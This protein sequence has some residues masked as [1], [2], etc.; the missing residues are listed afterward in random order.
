MQSNKLQEVLSWV[1]W[2]RTS[3]L[4]LGRIT[5]LPAG[6]VGDSAK[7]VIANAFTMQ[8]DGKEVYAS[9]G[10]HSKIHV[11][12]PL[13]GD[14]ID[15]DIDNPGLIEQLINHFDNRRML[16]Y[17]VP[18]DRKPG[19]L[20]ALHKHYD[21]SVYLTWQRRLSRHAP[22]WAKLAT[23]RGECVMGSDETFRFGHDLVEEVTDEA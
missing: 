19:E 18:E 16:E 9:I 20:R 3:K 12:N 17:I 23:E 5:S 13:T 7:C 2:I 1:N 10:G 14:R 8:A 11:V 15:Y 4:G 21:N 22:D 6:W